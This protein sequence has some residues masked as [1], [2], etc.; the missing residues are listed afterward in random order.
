MTEYYKELLFFVKKNVSN[1]D[2]ANDIVQD[3]FAKA[4]TFQNEK[5]I[6]NT[7][8]FLY[9][10]ARNIIIDESRKTKNVKVI[11]Y[12]DNELTV[13]SQEPEELVIAEDRQALLMRELKKLPE[14][15]KEAFV[16]HVI[17]GYSRQEIAKIMGITTVAVSKHISRATIELK[18]KI[19]DKEN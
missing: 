7:R 8:A 12:E 13:K 1:K 3:T 19:Q 15:R 16:L 10:L 11:P 9:K 4:I 14:K 6:E 5:P 17:E 18:E 2:F